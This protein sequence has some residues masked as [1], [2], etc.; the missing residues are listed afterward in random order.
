[1]PAISVS[2]FSRGHQY[3]GVSGSLAIHAA[4]FDWTEHYPAA[5]SVCDPK[6]TI[7]AMNRQAEKQTN[8][9][10]TEK[11][12]ERKLVHQAPWY[13][14]GQFAGLVETVIVPPPELETKQR[15]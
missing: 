3:W 13:D 11:K 15:S 4:A 9:Y 8:T 5:V 10:I 14:Q 12:G 1:M 2:D 7:L 6:G